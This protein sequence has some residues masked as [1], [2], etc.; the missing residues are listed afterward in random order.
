[1]IHRRT[2]QV[3]ASTSPLV[4]GAETLDGLI[5]CAEKQ[6]PLL[7]MGGGLAG[8]TA[9]V[10]L[11]GQLMLS[12]AECLSGLVLHQLCFPGAPIIYG[13]GSNPMDMRTTLASYCGPDAYLSN[14]AT[15]TLYLN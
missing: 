5:F 1:M 8:G 13:S 14:I 6:M 9:P 3:L 2:L 15:K 11:A 4:H 7:Y 12:N 10:T